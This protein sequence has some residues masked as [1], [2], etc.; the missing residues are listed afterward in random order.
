[1]GVKESFLN[2]NV[3]ESPLY[4]R[5]DWYNG[6]LLFWKMCVTNWFLV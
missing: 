1:M 6:L 2:Y 5:D 4:K 3:T